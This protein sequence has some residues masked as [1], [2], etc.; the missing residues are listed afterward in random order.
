MQMMDEKLVVMMTD[1]IVTHTIDWEYE[2]KVF[3]VR[4]LLKDPEIGGVLTG[5]EKLEIVRRVKLAWSGNQR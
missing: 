5:C 2:E 4:E 3:A 1:E